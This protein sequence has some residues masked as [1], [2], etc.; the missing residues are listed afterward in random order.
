V[1]PGPGGKRDVVG[2]HDLPRGLGRGGHNDGE[3]THAEQ[4]KWAVPEGEVPHGA[5]RERAD[6]VMQAADDRQLP[7]PRRWV[8]QALLAWPCFASEEE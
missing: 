8:R 5:V 6:E 4:H 3:L 1:G 2:L 7:W